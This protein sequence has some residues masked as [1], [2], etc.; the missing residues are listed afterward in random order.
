MRRRSHSSRASLLESPSSRAS[1][2]TRILLLAMYSSSALLLK[3]SFTQPGQ[4]DRID[5]NPQSTPEGPPAD[6]Q[7]EAGDLGTEPGSPPRLGPADG[8]RTVGTAGDA[9]QLGGLRHPPT[10][11]AR[12][13]C[14]GRERDGHGARHGRPPCCRPTPTPAPAPRPARD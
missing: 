5:L 13:Q 14:A 7:L 12:P 2:Y 8:D 4:L 3:Q 6:G 10:A 11:D 9:N 1:S